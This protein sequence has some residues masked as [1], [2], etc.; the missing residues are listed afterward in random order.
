MSRW[1]VGVKTLCSSHRTFGAGVKAVLSLSRFVDAGRF[2]L[3]E[4]ARLSQGVDAS[5]FPR[6]V[7]KAVFALSACP[8]PPH[9]GLGLFLSISAFA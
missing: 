8:L 2:L 4:D 3:T 9:T 1:S 6:E 5:R 7:I